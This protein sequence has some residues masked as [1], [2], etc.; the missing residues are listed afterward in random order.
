MHESIRLGR[1]FGIPVGVNWSV[2]VIA[3]LIAWTL[4]ASALP[5]IVPGQSGVA[6]WVT[7]VAGALVFFASLLTHELAHALVGRRNGVQIGGITLWL[8]GGVSKLEGEPSSAG[9]EFRIAIV[10][11]LTSFG[12]AVVFFALAA[13]ASGLVASI[14]TAPG[15]TA[16]LMEP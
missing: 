8:L 12:L 5:E 9:A 7:A 4:A 2:L 14:T 10:G 3:A 13:V 6:Y 11:P 16:S 1:I 15:R